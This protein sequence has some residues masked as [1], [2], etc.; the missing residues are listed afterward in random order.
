MIIIINEY[1][2]TV[3]I[4][5]KNRLFRVYAP[6]KDTAVHKFVKLCD[7]YSN[8]ENK[9]YKEH[10]EQ[11]RNKIRNKNYVIDENEDFCGVREIL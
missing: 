8:T 7:R 2:L 5:P 11:L 10:W 3:K 1:I 9:E 4:K 6:N